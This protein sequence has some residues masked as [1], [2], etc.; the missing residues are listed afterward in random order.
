MVLISYCSCDWQ[1]FSLFNCWIDVDWFE[2]WKDMTLETSF[3]KSKGDGGGY[4]GDWAVRID[5]QSEKWNDDLQKNAYLFFYLADEDGSAVSLSQDT[6]HIHGSSL[7]ASGSRADNGHRQLHLKSKIFHADPTPSQDNTPMRPER[8]IENSVHDKAPGVDDEPS[9]N[10]MK[11]QLIGLFCESF[12]NTASVNIDQNLGQPEDK[13]ANLAQLERFA[14]KGLVASIPNSTPSGE[15]TPY[16]GSIPKKE[17]S[18]QSAQCYL[19]GLVRSLSFG[20]RERG[21]L[22]KLMVVSQMFMLYESF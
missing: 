18:S 16:K 1:D 20:E 8:S 15:I 10:D 17:K 3:L 14:M 11:K 9:P 13:P 21:S 4:G 5:V 22:P 6:F 19:P 7:L 2:G 12:N